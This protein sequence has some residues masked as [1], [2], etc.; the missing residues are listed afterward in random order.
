MGGNPP[1]CRGQRARRSNPRPLLFLQPERGGRKTRGTFAAQPLM[2][3]LSQQDAPICLQPHDTCAPWR[4][5]PLHGPLRRPQRTGNVQRIS[6][7]TASA[8]NDVIPGCAPTHKPGMATHHLVIAASQHRETPTTLGPCLQRIDHGT[9][10][11]R[12]VM[13]IGIADDNLPPTLPGCRGHGVTHQ[14]LERL[15]TTE[16]PGGQIVHGLCRNGRHTGHRGLSVSSGP[17]RHGPSPHR[18]TT[19]A[20]AAHHRWHAP[21][22]AP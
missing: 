5:Q 10:A 20:T 12:P 9:L 8:G 18:T 7:R 21:A 6:G 11:Q 17:P 4:V 2:E 19:R 14:L 16:A 3:R 1:R 15:P 13:K 22:H